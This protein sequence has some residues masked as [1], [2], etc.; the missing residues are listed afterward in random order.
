MDVVQHFKFV[1]EDRH[2]NA[3]VGLIAL[4]LFVLSLY[5]SPL[6]DI[7]PVPITVEL[8][9]QLHDDYECDIDSASSQPEVR[10]GKIYP[11]CPADGRPLT[12]EP[13]TPATPS[14]IDRA[15][16]R[17]AE[18]Q[19]DWAKTT[20]TERR[21][22]LNTL[23][24]FVVDNQDS[25]V[26]AACLDSGK[27]KIDASFGEILVTAEKL[28][29][30]IK[31][32]EK[33]LKASRRPTNLLMCYKK[34]YVTYEPLGVVASCFSWN[35]PFHS[36]ISTVISALFSGNAI[37]N[38]PSEQ[39]C[40]SSQYFLS[41]VRTALST[42][43]HSPEL[44]Q[45]IICLPDV[46]DHLTSHPGISHIT[47]IGSRPIAHE[48]CASA[49]RSLTPVTV[50]LGGKDAVIVLDDK[51]TIKDVDSI[52][53]ILMRGTFQSAGQNCIGIERVIALPGIY[54]VLVKKLEAKVR[55]LRL[56]SIT[57]QKLGDEDIDMGSMISPA[58]FSRLES[59]ISSAVSAGA[60]LH[61]GGKRYDHPSHPHGHYF[62]P[63]LLSNVT[64]DMDLAQ[65]ELFAPVCAVMRADSV[66][67]AIELANSTSYGL[68]ASVFGAPTAANQKTLKRLAREIKSGMVSINDFGAYYVCSLPF[69]GVKGS[70]YGRF[71][72]EEGL[73]GLCNVKS[74]S[75][76]TWWAR[77]L[78]I[79]T[80]I[81][82][83]LQY[84]VSAKNG[85]AACEGIVSTG[86][87]PS[88]G[89]MVSGLIDLLSALVAGKK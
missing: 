37:I 30:T 11:R 33:A 43:G 3:A 67:H 72:G 59:F 42:L 2:T 50:E 78:G 39:T 6:E 31:H 71:G 5:V 41:I 49:A 38:K 26:K 29:W 73:R 44:A 58:S 53:A 54:D 69:G 83:P 22:V 52:V 66:N 70:G 61:A 25:I 88:W 13:I 47:F 28:Q 7:A 46:A 36:W 57:L 23:L 79:K 60:T 32:G 19:K 20:F 89:G 74:I 68:G 4:V 81:P 8:P 21:K 24:R 12:K 1:L 17:A 10:D 27:T 48:V 45:N 15:I 85:Y 51:S 16:A 87:A 62:S 86:Y 77:L 76:D 55:G 84:P 65:N 56:G 14:D 75:E 80:E 35:Y 9:P 18:A 34:N 82:S 64:L 40:W 63:T